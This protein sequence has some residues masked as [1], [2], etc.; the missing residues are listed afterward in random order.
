MRFLRLLQPSLDLL[1]EKNFRFVVQQASK[2]LDLWCS[3]VKERLCRKTNTSLQ[4]H[5]YSNQ[6]P[7]KNNLIWTSW[8]YIGMAMCIEFLSFHSDPLAE[9]KCSMHQV[10]CW[11]AS[12]RFSCCSQLSLCLWQVLNP[13]T[14]ATMSLVLS[15]N[16]SLVYSMVLMLQIQFWW[17]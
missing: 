6:L 4:D 10:K 13:D 12:Q 8:S 1:H 3:I 5:F 15:W 11:Y 16:R 2:Y 9:Q 7:S 17:K 14:K